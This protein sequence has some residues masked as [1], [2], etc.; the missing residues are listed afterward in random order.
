MDKEFKNG[1]TDID[2]DYIEMII[3]NFN[4][5]I[6]KNLDYVYLG[7]EVINDE[8]IKE[9]TI[10]KKEWNKTLDLILKTAINLE[11][12]ELCTSIKNILT[13]LK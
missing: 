2:A 13:H 12:Y 9:Y 1:K 11:E 4:S 8:E 10:P 7:Y 5:S 3:S 6:E